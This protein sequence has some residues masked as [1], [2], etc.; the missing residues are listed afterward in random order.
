MAQKTQR[1]V[2][3]LAAAFFLIASLTT[4]IAVIWTLT[5]QSKQGDTPVADNQ[6]QNQ[7]TEDP[8]AGKPMEGY[9]PSTEPV[10]ELKITDIK[11][12]D[13][14]EAKAGSTVSVSYV[15]AL[16]TTG[17]VFQSSQTPISLSLDQVITGWKDGVPG[18]KVGGT[19]RLVIPAAQAY[20][21]QSPD[22]SIPPNSDL[23]FDLT[24]FE[25]K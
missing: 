13:G 20:G 12:G 5:H 6:A 2:A 17:I 8:L 25:V 15:G 19:R 16:A 24:L 11:V 9:T 7:P 4:G 1:V 21:A 10:T 23:V 18:M 14:A 22:S 3:G